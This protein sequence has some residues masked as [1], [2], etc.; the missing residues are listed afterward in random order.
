MVTLTELKQKK[1]PSTKEKDTNA[2]KSKKR[3]SLKRFDRNLENLHTSKPEGLDTSDLEKEVAKLREEN[4]ILKSGATL[5]KNEEKILNAIRSEKIEQKT[6][7]PIISTSMLRKKYKVSPKYQGKSIKNLIIKRLIS[8]ETTSY[9]G[10]VKTYKWK[11][12]EQ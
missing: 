10:S 12:I 6:E 3:K 1:Q 9:S 2:K 5:T 11:I 4:K 7:H 8:R